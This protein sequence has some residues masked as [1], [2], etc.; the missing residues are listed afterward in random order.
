MPSGAVIGRFDAATYVDTP[1]EGGLMSV[2]G[3][4]AALPVARPIAAGADQSETYL[5]VIDLRHG[6][7]LTRLA[8]G[9]FTLPQPT[10]LPGASRFAAASATSADGQSVW[11]VRDTG[12][13]GQVARVYRFDV[14]GLTGPVA[15][16]V[17]TSTDNTTV[18]S[19][20]IPL[21]ADKLLVMREHYSS[22]KSHCCRLVRPGCRTE[23]AQDGTRSGSRMSCGEGSRMTS[24]ATGVA[25]WD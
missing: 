6:G 21:G 2:T 14:N 10:D 16:A 23:C 1:Q 24:D 25:W 13:R 15:H 7:A 4:I 11:L 17:L 3:D 12:D 22:L 8:T 9:T 18:R 20:V 5:Q 19:R